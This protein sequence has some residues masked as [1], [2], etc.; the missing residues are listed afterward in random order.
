M[1]DLADLIIRCGTVFD[2]ADGPRSGFGL[3]VRSYA[4]PR[5]HPSPKLF[6][7][8]RPKL[9]TE[10]DRQLCRGQRPKRKSSPSQLSHRSGWLSRNEDNHRGARSPDRSLRYRRDGQHQLVLQK[11]KLAEPSKPHPGLS[12]WVHRNLSWP[13]PA[14]LTARRRPWSL[15]WENPK[16][17]HP[18]D[19][20]IRR[21]TAVTIGAN[22]NGR[23]VLPRRGHLRFRTA[24]RPC[25]Q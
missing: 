6:T 8:R 25:H 19:A 15:L 9:F 3:L 20:A 13:S 12:T 5:P 18:R 16:I 1:R 10:A 21:K 22:C 23:R 17:H 24:D 4:N 14:H 11:P 2:G 7:D